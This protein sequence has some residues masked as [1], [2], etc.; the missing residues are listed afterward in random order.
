MTLSLAR[1]ELDQKDK[2]DEERY[3]NEFQS[4]HSIVNKNAIMQKELKRMRKQK[5]ELIAEISQLETHNKKLTDAIMKYSRGEALNAKALPLQ[6]FT[7]NNNN[8]PDKSRDQTLTLINES[9]RNVDRI[10][11]NVGQMTKIS[12]E[13]TSSHINNNYS[14]AKSLS[15]KQLKE[16]IE[17]IY[18]SKLKF[19]EKN[20]QGKL[21]RETM[22]QYLFTYL[23]QKYGLK[24]TLLSFRV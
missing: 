18:E 17:E 11:S 20:Y 9:S 10:R 1:I 23:S 21:A 19:D 15:L 16:I 4:Q 3:N 5:D 2:E 14:S 22:N 8:N 7:P 24:V 6:T 13:V 12:R